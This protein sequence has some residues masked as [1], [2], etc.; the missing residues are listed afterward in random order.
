VDTLPYVTIAGSYQT[1][2]QGWRKSHRQDVGRQTRRLESVGALTLRAIE[3]QQAA[4]A[5]LPHFLE[6]HTLNW[7]GMDFSIESK[8][9]SIQSFFDSLINEETSWKLVHFSALELDGKP[10]SYHFGFLFQDRF[11]WYKPAYDREFENYSPGKVHIAKLL[12]SG[13]EHEWRIFDLLKGAEPYKES[14]ADGS[15]TTV[16]VVFRNAGMLSA[17]NAATAV[18]NGVVRSFIHTLM[19]ALPRRIGR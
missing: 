3:D 19:R 6:M 9:R 2:A 4:R 13:V 17:V 11:Y 7:S 14:W 16:D 1:I 18:A 15:R 8:N 10:I 5:A 12:E